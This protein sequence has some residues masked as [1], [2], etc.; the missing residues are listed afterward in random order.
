[1]HVLGFIVEFSGY[2][3]YLVY[4]SVEQTDLTV[5]HTDV[6]VLHTDVIVLHTGVIVLHTDVTVM[7]TNVTVLHTDV[8]VLQST[9][10]HWFGTVFHYSVI[11]H[12]STY[13]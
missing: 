8:T 1:M 12:V 3:G 11:L 7:H 4:T 2:V 5:L 10:P 9:C 13:Q 6:I